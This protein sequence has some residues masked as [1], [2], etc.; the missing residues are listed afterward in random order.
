[1]PDEVVSDTDQDDQMQKNDYQKE[2]L[3]KLE[4]LGNG[5]R[6]LWTTFLL[7]LTPGILNGFHTSSYVFL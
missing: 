6:W 3:Q 1:M 7:C 2:I 5:S 4:E